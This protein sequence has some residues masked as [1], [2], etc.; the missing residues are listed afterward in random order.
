MS[1][2]FLLAFAD[3]E[4]K[5]SLSRIQKRRLRDC[6]NSLDLPEKEFMA[7]FRVNKSGCQQVLAE[8][9]PFLQRAQRNTAVAIELKILAVLNFYANGSYQRSSSFICNMSQPT[10]SRCLHEVTDALNVRDVLLKYIKFPSTQQ[11][12]ESTMK[13][14]MEKFGF[15]GV[16]GC[17]DGTHVAIIRP[18][19]HEEAFFNRK[20]YHS[21]NVL[22]ICDANLQILHVDASYGGASHDSFVWNQCCIKSHL[23]GLERSG[24]HCWL[25]GDSGYAQRPWMMTPILEAAVGSPEEHYT[26]LHCKV[27]NTVERCI[28][29]LK[30]RWRCLLAHRVLH[31]DPVTVAKI[32]NACVVLHNIAN[33]HNVPL[34]EPES[35][36]S[37]YFFVCCKYL[38]I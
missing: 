12:R 18:T 25:L 4:R 11:E 15:P 35:E 6:N 17:I 31:Y 16:I 30:N 29:V 14:F 20:H 21:L 13:V 8:L 9:R 1:R 24:E 22:L 34:P 28:G 38:C 19:D 23:E 37:D 7:N 36:E 26:T 33:I 3:E 27:R 2:A 10:F 5:R 32:V